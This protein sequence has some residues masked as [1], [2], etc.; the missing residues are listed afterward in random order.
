MYRGVPDNALRGAVPGVAGP[1]GIVRQALAA[2]SGRGR[3]GS[4]R[5]RHAQR[6]PFFGS[7]RPAR[8]SASAIALLAGAGA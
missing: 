1:A 5:P 8:R 4:P 2:L 3:G 7:S 6:R